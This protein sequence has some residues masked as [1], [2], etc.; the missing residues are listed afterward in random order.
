MASGQRPIVVWFRQDLR[1]DDNPAWARAVSSGRPIAPLYI[2]DDET[3]GRWR[4]GGA[5]RWWLHRS[6]EALDASLRRL[7]GRLILRAGPSDRVLADVLAE[8]GAQAAVW[9]RL[10]E[11]FAIARDA[12]IKSDLASAGIDVAS[13]NAALLHEPWDVATGAGGPFKVFTPF[14]KACLA[15]GAPPPVEADIAAP[16]FVETNGDR[17]D[18]WRLLPTRP[19]WAAG[20]EPLW[21]PGEAGAKARLATFIDDGLARYA[22]E[23]DRPDRDSTSRLSP[24]LH[25]GEI[26]PRR[27]WQAVQH[28]AA[29]RPSL[30]APAAKFLS[31]IGWRE[32]S[33]HLLYHAPHLPERNFRPDFDAFPWADDAPAFA[34]WREGRTGVPIVDAGMRELWRTGVMHN[35]VRM[36][37]ASFLTKHLLV[38]WTLGADWFWDTLVDA[39]L[40]NNS[41]SWQ[42]VAGCGADAAPY[43][44][45]FNPVLQGLKFDPDGAYV[46]RFVPEL[47][48]LPATVIHEPWNASAS[49]LAAAGV[50][51]GE[52]YPRP[53][54]DLAAGRD[55]ALAAYRSL[56]PAVSPPS[57]EQ[58]R[59]ACA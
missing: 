46:R 18:A 35:R 10:Y 53:I 17:L 15:R 26:G 43:F 13:F 38:S 3:P 4:M 27:I 36:I 31:E 51:L 16:R 22:A 19:N 45:I 11:P 59:L 29:A 44:R 2:L 47:A 8:T 57:S 6:L 37:A 5:S 42:W 33:Y 1:L 58:D 32:F 14:W 39:D 12:R 9:N 40:A 55:R 50:T 48:A 23:R 41:A 24:H 54:V 56:K 20:F 30:S 28:A 52:S 21:T 25:W 7:G 49:V 34:A